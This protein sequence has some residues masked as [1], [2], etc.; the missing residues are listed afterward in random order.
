MLGDDPVSEWF[1]KYPHDFKN[2]HI[3]HINPKNK[4]VSN[5]MIPFRTLNTNKIQNNS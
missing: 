5:F 2:E 1:K 4:R 3:V